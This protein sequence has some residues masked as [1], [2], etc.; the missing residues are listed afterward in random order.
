MG[1][2]RWLERSNSVHSKSGLNPFIQY[3]AEHRSLWNHSALGIESGLCEPPRDIFRIR[4]APHNKS[5]RILSRTERRA[6][7]D[8]SEAD[9]VKT[10]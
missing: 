9:L 4:G 6:R 2:E 1:Y 7:T 5:T 10:H 3:A 8:A